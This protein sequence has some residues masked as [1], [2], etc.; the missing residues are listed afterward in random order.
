M[1]HRNRELKLA[2][3]FVFVLILGMVSYFVATQKS[4]ETTPVQVSQTSETSDELLNLQG[5]EISHVKIVNRFG[6]IDIVK[7][8]LSE[9]E[10]Q[11]TVA[12]ATTLASESHETNLDTN[13]DTN[14]ETNRETTGETLHPLAPQPKA[15]Y[16]YRMITPDYKEQSETKLSALVEPLRQLVIE[17][18]VGQVTNLKTYGLDPPTAKAHI[19]TSSGEQYDLLLGGLVPGYE[20]HYYLLRQD[21]DR[22]VIVKSAAFSLLKDPIDLLDTTVIPID[23]TQVQEIRLE[24]RSSHFQFT[25]KAT[26]ASYKDSSGTEKTYTTWQMEDPVH[27]KGDDNMINRLV[28]EMAGLTAVRYEAYGPLWERRMKQLESLQAEETGLDQGAIDE[29]TEIETAAHEDADLSETVDPDAATDEN[30]DEDLDQTSDLEGEDA[31]EP[32]S[33]GVRNKSKNGIDWSLFGLDQ[34]AYVFYI[35]DGTQHYEI[36]VGRA[37]GD[38]NMYVRRVGL[39]AV[40]LV[41]L[42]HFKIFGANETQWIDRFAALESIDNVKSLSLTLDGHTRSFDLQTPSQAEIEAAEAKGEIAPGERFVEVIDGRHVDINRKDEEGRSVFK[43]FYQSLIGIMVDG[44]DLDSE[45]AEDAICVIKYVHKDQSPDTEL[46]LVPRES[47][48]YYIVLNGNYTGLYASASEVD[49]AKRLDDLGVR[50]ALAQMDEA[51]ASA[52]ESSV[53]TSAE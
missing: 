45:P 7:E 12:S 25:A 38:G 43:R 21:T 6:E 37:S 5:T 3:L 40:L 52:S 4:K 48:G 13:L 15:Q 49:E 9:E 16:R 18:E 27:W 23:P 41:D 22:V 19:E 50:A 36:Q 24:N 10:T 28:E 32:S 42:N 8:A 35:S 39:D 11:K 30:A 53:E 2:I 44:F 33:D 26:K 46:A 1:S 31:A 14:L 34:P 29:D 51:L 17:K 47:G 20:D